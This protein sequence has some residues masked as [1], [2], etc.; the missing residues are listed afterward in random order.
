MPVLNKTVQTVMAWCGVAFVAIFFTGLIVAGF[1]PPIPP[2]HDAAEVAAQY[3]SEAGAI[4]TGCLIM[5]IACGFTIPF[6]AVVCA[7]LVRI[8][9]RFSPITFACAMAGAVGVLAATLPV[10]IW[11]AA[12]F[13]PDR[14]PQITQAMNDLGWFPFIM[15]YPFAVAQDVL[16]AVAI[17]SD[18]RLRRVYPRWVAYYLLY[19]AAGAVPAGFLTYFKTGPFAWD[20]LFSFWLAAFFF[21]SAFLVLTWGTLKAIANQYA[22][23]AQENLPL[24]TVDA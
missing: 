24:A 3:Q 4:R 23:A 14:D 17:L 19:A 16:I 15:N 21:G 13:R 1:F 10:L 8:E 7:Q 9:G 12:A 2:G 11:S 22:E 6:W 5:M 18:R 20:G